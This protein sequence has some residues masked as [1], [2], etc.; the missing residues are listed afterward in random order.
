MQMMSLG[1]QLAGEA[2]NFNNLFCEITV[3][4]STE[5]S[6]NSENLPRGSGL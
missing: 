1:M 6:K 4:G 5:Q 3:Y 2:Q